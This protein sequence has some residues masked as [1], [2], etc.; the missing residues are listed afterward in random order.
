MTSTTEPTKH[1]LSETTWV[2]LRDP[3]AVSEKR[4]RPLMKL[5]KHMQESPLAAALH[6]KTPLEDLVLSDEDYDLA[7]EINDALSLALVESWSRESEISLDTITDLPGPEY[8]A[9]QR[10][11]APL[12]P[13]L[14]PNFEPTPDLASPTA[15]SPT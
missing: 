11:V 3:K 5:I 12:F 15:P 6:A 4:R 10:L 9:L 8:D 7:Q 2:T 1:P 14:K 13:E